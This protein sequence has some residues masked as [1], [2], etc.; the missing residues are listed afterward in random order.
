MPD[1]LFLLDLASRNHSAY[2]RLIPEFP[3]LR[4]PSAARE[5]SGVAPSLVSTGTRLRRPYIARPFAGARAT[6]IRGVPG[7]M[8]LS[9]TSA[10]FFGTMYAERED[11]WEFAS[12]QYERDRYAA[13]VRALGNRRYRRAFEP[14]APSES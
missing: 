14:G 2:K 9:P 8:S 3:T 1:I 6:P 7:R 12:S 13:I 11:P 5:D 4:F 10:E